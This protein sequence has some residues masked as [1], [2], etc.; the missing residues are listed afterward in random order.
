MPHLMPNYADH[1]VT[2]CLKLVA[3]DKASAEDWTDLAERYMRALSQA[4]SSS[5]T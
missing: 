3:D 1:T 4:P 2:D 5:P